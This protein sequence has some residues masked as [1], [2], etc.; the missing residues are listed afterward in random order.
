MH[1]Y[2]LLFAIVVGLTAPLAQADLIPGDPIDIVGTNNFG[3][4]WGTGVLGGLPHTF[5]GLNLYSDTVLLSPIT[6]QSFELLPP[7]PGKKFAGVIEIT[8][9]SVYLGFFQ[10]E[11]IDIG[12][13]KDA[14]GGNL[15][16]SVVV[17]GDLGAFS[18]VTT[19]GFSITFDALTSDILTVGG[20]VV[21]IQWGQVPAPGTLA[22]LAVAGLMG[23]RRRR[24]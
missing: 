4:R 1:R 7:P 17:L 20:G 2:A 6:V 23:G 13:I 9:E 18:T 14:A 8:Y 10:A 21:Q 24:R 15:I 3:T 11:H 22:L 16:N 19:D 12:P 5:G